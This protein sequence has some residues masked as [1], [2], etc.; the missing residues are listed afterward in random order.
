MEKIEKEKKTQTLPFVAEA[1][2]KY[3]VK[4]QMDKSSNRKKS[5]SI[6]PSLRHRSDA[7]PFDLSASPRNLTSYTENF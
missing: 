6:E 3:F 5:M 7:R 2:H 4:T 1:F